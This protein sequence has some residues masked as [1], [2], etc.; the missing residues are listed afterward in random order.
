MPQLYTWRTY[1]FTAD[2]WDYN[3]VTDSTGG[4]ELVYFFS[5]SIELDVT[6][7]EFGR[8]LCEFKPTEGNMAPMWRLFNLRDKNGL[9]LYPAGVWTLDT[10]EPRLNA[11]KQREGF[12]GRATL[13]FEGVDLG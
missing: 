7:D 9:E 6:Q 5:K 2:A 1:G 10:Y 4:S 11:F 3:I 13:T 8:I 12:R